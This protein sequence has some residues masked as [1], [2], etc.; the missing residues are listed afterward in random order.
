[1]LDRFEQQMGNEGQGMSGGGQEADRAD[2][3]APDEWLAPEGWA[4]QPDFMN[5]PETLG[6]GTLPS[7]DPRSGEVFP[8]PPPLA[9]E[10]SWNT[11]RPALD[12]MTWREFELAMADVFRARGYVVTL[13]PDGADGG[14]D[15]VLDRPG[16]H[17]LVQCKHWNV[18]K[19]GVKVVRELYGVMAAHGAT[20]GIVVTS[21][22][23]TQEARA[24]AA[25]TNVTLLDR[26]DVTAIP[27]E[28][29]FAKARAI[30]K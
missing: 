27:V 29:V 6:S 28:E 15:L 17:I 20:G 12:A 13:T 3:H 14:V 16:E 25:S 18:L 10:G 8:P 2:S 4:G 9:N 30:A 23:F 7:F 22:Q 11:S 1:M 26:G 19:V 24:F 5:A 21:G